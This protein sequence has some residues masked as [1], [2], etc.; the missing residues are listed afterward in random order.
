M[1]QPIR[2][3]RAARM[4]KEPEMDEKTLIALAKQGNTDALSELFRSHYTMLRG[5]LIKIS[6]SPELAEDLAQDTM[7]KAMQKLQLY[8]PAKS[9]WSTWLITIASR[10][11]LDHLRKVKRDRQLLEEEQSLRQLRWRAQASNEEW[12][13]L[14]DALGSLDPNLRVPIIMKHYYGFSQEEI[15]AILEVP[16]GTIKSR[17]HNGIERIRKEMSER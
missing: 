11:Y 2:N 4:T 10:L 17:I 15:A 7:I 1:N 5:Y 12:H 14:L 3:A 9:S 6:L 8:D 13:E 16:S